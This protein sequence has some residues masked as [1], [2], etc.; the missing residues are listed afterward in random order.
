MLNNEYQ[1]VM[2][3]LKKL[4]TDQLKVAISLCAEKMNA[5]NSHCEYSDRCPMFD[6][7]LHREC[8]DAP[9]IECFERLMCDYVLIKKT[10]EHIR[11]SNVK[12]DV[13]NLLLSGKDKQIA[14]L[15][16]KVQRLEALNSWR[17]D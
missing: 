13:V 5:N 11:N 16:E 4:N 17:A 1:Y 7:T 14:E 6:K 12:I 9:T 2:E 10:D 3:A 15:T 8:Y